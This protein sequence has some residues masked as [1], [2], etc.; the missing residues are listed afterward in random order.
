MK[1]DVRRRFDAVD[2]IARHAGGKAA[3]AHEHMDF[4]GMLCEEYRGL[5]GRITAADEDHLAARAHFGFERGGPVPD[6]AA[7]EL[8]QSR[9]VGPPILRTARKNDCASP[10]LA[11]VAQRDIAFAV[12]S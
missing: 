9:H 11:P 7:L 6:A 12:F 1:L 3:S 10:Q 2:Q 8:A 5:A 4:G